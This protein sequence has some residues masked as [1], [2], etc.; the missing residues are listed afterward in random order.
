M[1]NADPRH[2]VGDARSRAPPGATSG[3]GEGEGWGDWEKGSGWAPAINA[4]ATNS[5]V[6]FA[7][8]DGRLGR[9]SL[10]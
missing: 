6:S 2:D 4:R 5:L 9:C 1:K 10:P 7:I 3:R 8:G